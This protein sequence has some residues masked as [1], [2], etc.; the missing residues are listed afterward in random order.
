L[1][2]QLVVKLEADNVLPYDSQ[3]FFFNGIGLL[4]SA[5]KDKKLQQDTLKVLLSALCYRAGHEFALT[6]RVVMTLRAERGRQISGPSGGDIG[7]GDLQ[8]GHS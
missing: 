2:D 5:T 1:Q 6:R 3:L 4:L 7:Q 8:A